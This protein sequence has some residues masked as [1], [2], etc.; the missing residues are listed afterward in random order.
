MDNENEIDDNEEEEE[1][2]EELDIEEVTLTQIQEDGEVLVLTDGRSLLVNPSDI[3]TAV[4]WLPS[5]T[6]EVVQTDEDEDGFF[7]LSVILEETDEEIR[8]RWETESTT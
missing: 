1:S 6:L 7:N 2:I 5:S 3:S 8:A 4:L